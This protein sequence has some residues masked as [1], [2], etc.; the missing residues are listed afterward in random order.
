M[1]NFTLSIKFRFY[2]SPSSLSNRKLITIHGEERCDGVKNIYEYDTCLRFRKFCGYASNQ[3][4]IGI[5]IHWD[6]LGPEEMG[7]NRLIVS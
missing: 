2:S 5:A 6:P 1:D 3:T 7:L 4:Q